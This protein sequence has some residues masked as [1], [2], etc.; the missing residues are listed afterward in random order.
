MVEIDA[1]TQELRRSELYTLKTRLDDA[2]AVGRDVLT[3][4]A[5][6]VSEQI[7]RAKAQLEADVTA[8]GF[9]DVMS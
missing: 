3:E 2:H 7:V 4:M 9:S 1:E 8:R 6:K 5:S